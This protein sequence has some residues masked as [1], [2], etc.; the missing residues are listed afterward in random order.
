MRSIAGAGY[1]RIRNRSRWLAP[2]VVKWL[3]QPN[4]SMRPRT[5][6]CGSEWRLEVSPQ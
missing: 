6:R 3:K 5:K 1:A 4:Q 2:E